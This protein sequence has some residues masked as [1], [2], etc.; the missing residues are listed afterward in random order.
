MPQRQWQW[1][2]HAGV[3]KYRNVV[4]RQRQSHWPM[5]GTVSDAAGNWWLRT[6][7]MMLSAS[8][9]ATPAEHSA[10][11]QTRSTV[12]QRLVLYT[13]ASDVVWDRPSVLGQD[14][15]ETKKLRLVLG[16]GPIW[17]SFV[18]HDLVT[19][20]VTMILNDTA[21]F[22]VLFIVSLF[23]AWNITTVEINSGVHLLK[24]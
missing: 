23:C 24:C 6:I 1:W 4:W 5:N 10:A 11:S 3:C 19:L 18:K 22:Q 2:Q 12:R 16:L 14:R 7:C 20:V 21:T 13:T 15:S 9:I 17:C 8:N